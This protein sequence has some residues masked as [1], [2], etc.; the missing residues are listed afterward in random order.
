MLKI[1]VPEV[2]EGQMEAQTVTQV[3]S[4]V[5]QEP[6]SAPVPTQ[7]YTKG[8]GRGSPE[9]VQ[10]GNEMMAHSHI[11]PLLTARAAAIDGQRSG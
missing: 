3:G 2:A 4:Q 11:D 1:L 7:L 8:I 9:T 6:T 5:Q 10:L